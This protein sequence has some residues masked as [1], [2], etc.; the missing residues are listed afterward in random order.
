MS[1][2]VESI[3]DPAPSQPPS[4]ASPTRFRPDIE[5]LRAIA[6]VAVL[7]FHAGVPGF[8]GGFV[9]VDVFF[10]I[11]GFLIT[12]Q[13]LRDVDG[14]GLRFRDFYARRAR[15]LLPAATL[16]IVATL[17]GSA[18]FL[19]PLQQASTGADARAATLFYSN[20]RFAGEATDYFA[21]AQNPSPYQHFW[22]LSVEEQFYLVWPANDTTTIA[23]STRSRRRRWAAAAAPTPTR[24]SSTIAGHTR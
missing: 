16:V 19:S 8:E 23:P 24:A 20:M 13:M 7:A 6:V 1:Q 15:R 22:S 18:L 14:T 10:V 11:S 21:A 2:T 3:A 17:I 12:G 4:A 9:G 5:G